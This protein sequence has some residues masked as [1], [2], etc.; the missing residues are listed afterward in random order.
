MKKTNNSYSIPGFLASAASAGLKKNGG[1][2]L[3]LIFSQRKAVAAGLFTTNKVK[4]APVLLSQKRIKNGFLRAIIANAGCANACT[5]SKGLN[6]AVQ[7]ANIVAKGLGIDPEETAVASTGV[8]GAYLPLNLIKKAV[9]GLISSLSPTGFNSVAE[10]LMT[11]DSFPK[12]SYFEG[13]VGGHP[14]HLLGIAKGAGMIMPNMATMLSFLLTDIYI[15]P[16]TL[17]PIFQSTVE[18]TFNRITVDGETSTNDTV[19]IMANGFAGNSRLNASDIKEFKKG[20]REVMGELAYMIAKDG[21]GA[22]KVVI[23]EVKGAAT[24]RDANLAARTVANSPLVKTAIF[25]EDPNWGRIIAALGKSGIKMEENKVQIWINDVKVTEGGL[26]TSE[27]KEKEA[28]LKMKDERIT[29]NIHLHQGN[30][31]D[32][33][34]TCDLTY[35]YIKINAA[36]RS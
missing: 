20:L 18:S 29:I 27:K 15:D 36:Y 10:A 17:L 6:D 31:T 23:I 32:R 16:Q 21:E 22:T 1:L 26:M 7:T 14:F 4:A 8:I 9:P 19:I 13:T 34:T 33:F 12:T 5:G 3:S 25:G 24:K 2:D 30:Q 11:T 35:D 28:A